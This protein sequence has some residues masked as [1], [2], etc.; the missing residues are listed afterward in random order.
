M[1]Y[2]LTPNVPVFFVT[3]LIFNALQRDIGIYIGH[4]YIGIGLLTFW[5]HGAKPIPSKARVAKKKRGDRVPA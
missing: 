4:A 1:S 3:I 2:F 5:G